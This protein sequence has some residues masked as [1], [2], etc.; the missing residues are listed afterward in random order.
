VPLAAK[1]LAA[2]IAPDRFSPINLIA[3]AI[4]VPGPLD[5]AI[6]L[7]LI[8]PTQRLTPPALREELRSQAA[9]MAERPGSRMGTA[10]MLWDV[11][12]MLGV[13]RLAFAWAG[14]G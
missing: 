7:P 1:L 3:E 12:A 2:A 14:G 13:W 6:L 11:A 4:P 5:E 8:L 10:A 9:E